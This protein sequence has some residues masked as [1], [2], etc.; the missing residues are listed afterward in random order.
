MRTNINVPT[1]QEE[2]ALEYKL[3]A[4]AKAELRIATVAD[5]Q[6]ECRMRIG[7]Y[8]QRIRRLEAELRGGY[9]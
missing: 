3:L 9:G 1:V 7:K 6:I 4:Q 8:S 5:E 2:L